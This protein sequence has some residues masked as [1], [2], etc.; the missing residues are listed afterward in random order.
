MTR[1]TA[2]LP[3]RRAPGV[4]VRGWR[5]GFRRRRV[6]R[7]AREVAAILVRDGV[8][9]AIE[10]FRSRGGGGVAASTHEDE[11]Y[12]TWLASTSHGEQLAEMRC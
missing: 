3:M 5:P 2:Q 12:R 1:A 11:L 4:A 10:R 6:L 8:G 9:A 7:G